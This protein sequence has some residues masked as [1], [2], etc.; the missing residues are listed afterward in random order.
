[1]NATASEPPPVQSF[2]HE[3]IRHDVP[4]RC[5]G[6]IFESAVVTPQGTF[7]EALVS[8][9]VDA[10][11]GAGFRVE[12]RVGRRREDYW[13]PY[14]YLGDWGPVLPPGP[15]L[16]QCETGRVAVDIFRSDE[17]FDRAQYRLRAVAAAGQPAELCIQHIT[18]C[19]SARAAVPNCQTPAAAPAA[20]Q[21]GRLPVPF[22]SQLDAHPALSARIC[23]PTSLAMV[24]QYRGVNVPTEAVAAACYDPVHDIYGNWPRNIQAAHSFGVPGYLARFSDWRAVAEMIAAGQPLVISIRFSEPGALSGAPFAATDGHLLVLCG[25]D[26]NGDM[27]VNDPAAAG[28]QNGCTVYRRQEL[29]RVWLQGSGGVSYVLLSP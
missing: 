13:T 25:F 4:V 3:L 6:G 1:M 23:S 29:E 14:L 19:L 24:M 17:S 2:R 10:P 7:N 9:N 26:A 12:L 27:Y 8:W 21:P 18:L 5:E 15:R 22:R 20:I 11:S 16:T 28:L